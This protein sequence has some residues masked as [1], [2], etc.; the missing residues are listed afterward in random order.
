MLGRL[1]P[2]GT[3]DRAGRLAWSLLAGASNRVARV[4]GSPSWWHRTAGAHLH[5]EQPEQ[6]RDAIAKALRS[7]KVE[8]A[9][10]TRAAELSGDLRATG[11]WAE[12]AALLAPA[13]AAPVDH[14]D[15]LFQLS[16]ACRR[17][18]TWGGSFVGE[19]RHPSQA[20]FQS[21]S[22]GEAPTPTEDEVTQLAEDAL[23]RAVESAGIRVAA[24]AQ[25]AEHL[26]SQGHYEEAIPLLEHAIDATR[27]A[28][29]HWAFVR[30][31]RWQHALEYAYSRMAN[32]RVDDP[33]FECTL[34]VPAADDGWGDG[35][36][37]AGLFDASFVFGGLYVTGLLAGA[38][39]EDLIEIRLDG[40]VV[41]P[42]NTGG[43]GF[44]PAFSI[45]FQRETLEGFPKE[46]ELSVTTR[47][48][49]HLW[50]RGRG[51]A[52]ELKVPHGTGQLLEALGRGVT[53]NKKGVVSATERELKARQEAYLDLYADVRRFF[54]DELGLSLMLMYGTLLG[55]YRDGDLIPG[56]DDFDAGYISAASDPVAAKEETKA[57]IAELVRAG[58]L[59]SFNRRGRLFRAQRGDEQLPGIHLDLR[60][61]WFEDGKVWVHNH[62][63]FPATLEH[64]LPA[65]QGTLRGI[66]VDVPRDTEHFLRSHY[67]PGWKVP[68]PGF[69]YHA[70]DVDDRVRQH[71]AKALIS[72]LEYR[73]LHAQIEAERDQIPGMGR[74]VAVGAQDLYPLDQFVS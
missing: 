46:V 50:A 2:K 24:H 40:Q 22:I 14:Y 15:A 35:D 68:D 19:A 23:R 34:N 38:A 56:D 65:T 53:I 70:S 42:L 11:R 59:I 16:K 1:L 3:D 9:H 72:P 60:P 57:I 32:P 61:L 63:S 12:A 52:I 69:V 73:E 4:T 51:E 43:D 17:M 48:G 67:G 66:E 13:A 49:R 41:R 8:D 33:L 39:D 18:I 54:A 37:P 7:P 31:H 10:L 20:T 36:A 29:G 6:A 28:K 30:L 64:F 55:Y 44:F 74:F 27:A 62:A 26:I 47:S 5:L 21:F 71:L 58:Y 25:L 45:T